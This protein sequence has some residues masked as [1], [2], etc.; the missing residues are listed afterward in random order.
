[1][2]HVVNL[3]FPNRKYQRYWFHPSKEMDQEIYNKYSVY[4][5]KDNNFYNDFSMNPTYL[6]GQ[7][8][9]FD[10]F[11]RQC[12][13]ISKSIDLD[14]C[15]KIALNY[16]KIFIKLKYHLDND[17]PVEQRLFALMPLRHSFK[18]KNLQIVLSIAENYLK[19]DDPIGMKH[20]NRFIKA[21]KYSLRTCNLKQ[22]AKLQMLTKLR[23]YDN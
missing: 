6:L 17:I 14:K 20:V 18:R 21:T 15:N 22:I 2:Q 16:S 9:I 4:L 3:W 1:M 19:L 5:K 8:L 11:S 13:R 10:Q 7:I 23:Q 12:K